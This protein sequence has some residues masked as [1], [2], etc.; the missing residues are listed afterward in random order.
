MFP[1]PSLYTV[2]LQGGASGKECRRHERLGF[3]PSLGDFPWSKKWHPA[4][5]FLSGKF[6]GQ[7]SLAGYSLWGQKELS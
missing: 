3:S 7:K 4:T 5:V 2:D 6:H 1:P